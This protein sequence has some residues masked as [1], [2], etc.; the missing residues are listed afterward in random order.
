MFS[1]TFLLSTNHKY[2]GS[3]TKKRGKKRKEQ[4][5]HNYCNGL[6]RLPADVR[7]DCDGNRGNLTK[8]RWCVSS[9]HNRA[10]HRPVRDEL[11]GPPENISARKHEMRS[12]FV[13]R[14]RQMC[15]EFRC[16]GG[17]EAP[18]IQ[19]EEVEVEEGVGEEGEVS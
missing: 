16:L 3:S 5:T 4:F 9:N 18:Q 13:F 14:I 8:M 15:S 12:Y 17:R 6:F 19:Q 2:C 11:L 1:E 10:A 7:F